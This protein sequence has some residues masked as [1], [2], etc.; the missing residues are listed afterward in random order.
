M[1]EKSVSSRDFRAECGSQFGSPADMLKKIEFLVFT[2]GV[3]LNP[4]TVQPKH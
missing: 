3:W 1:L 2:P 4:V